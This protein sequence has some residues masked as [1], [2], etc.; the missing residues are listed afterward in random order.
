MVTADEVLK[1]RQQTLVV[2]KTCPEVLE[3][4]FHKESVASSYHVTA[5]DEEI[6]VEED[7]EDAPQELE[8]GVKSTVDDLKEVNLGTQD[9]PL[10]TF[11]SSLL[12]PQEEEN[13]VKLLREYKDVFAWSYKEMPGLDPKVA[14]HHLAIKHGAQPIKQA[15]RSFRP[16]LIPRIE[17]EVNKLIEAGFI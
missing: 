8:E 17:V 1:V 12:N 10:P 9:E 14:I 7:A 13:Y 15:Q 11:I 16:E 4:N 5:N 2:T 6:Q 3:D